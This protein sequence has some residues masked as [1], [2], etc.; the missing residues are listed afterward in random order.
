MPLKHRGYSVHIEVE[1][2]ELPQFQVE[3]PDER[4]MTCWMPSEAGK[5]TF[6]LQ[7]FDTLL[8]CLMSLT[9]HSQSRFTLST[10]TTMNLRVS[11]FLRMG[12]SYK[13]A[14]A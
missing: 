8:T 11:G 10:L 13:A 4:T 12:D 1:G 2:E 7:S 6:K 3:T 14:E 5:V 9:R